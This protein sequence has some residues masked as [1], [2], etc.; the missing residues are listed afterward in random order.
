MR[1]FFDLHNDIDSIDDE[2][3]DLPSPMAAHERGVLEAREMAKASISE[4]GH[5]DLRHFIQIRNEE[6]EIIGRIA[7]EE[8]IEF[9]REGVKV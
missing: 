2:G 3:V 9:M 4:H 7:F 6:R 5:I 1:F 8:A